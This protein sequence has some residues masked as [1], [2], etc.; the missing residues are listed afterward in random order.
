MSNLASHQTITRMSYGIDDLADAHG[1]S[2][3]FWR[4][5][6]REGRL[7]SVRLGKRVLVLTADLDAYLQ[8]RRT[9]VQT[10]QEAR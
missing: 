4:K 3:S 10:P 2:R 8:N 5:E 1:N 6:I 7:P 9:R